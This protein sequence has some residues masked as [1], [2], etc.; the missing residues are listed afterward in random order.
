MQKEKHDF[1][2]IIRI[3]GYNCF[4]QDRQAQHV[5]DFL[6]LEHLRTY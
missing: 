2:S 1:P 4:P 3:P 6:S 5:L